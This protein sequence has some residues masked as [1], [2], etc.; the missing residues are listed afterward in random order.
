MVRDG[1]SQADR[2]LPALDP[3]YAPVDGRDT[4]AYLEYLRHY[5]RQLR[6][7]GLSNLPAGDWAPFIEG[8]I[9][10][11]AAAVAAQDA[12]RERRRLLAF[13]DDVP[14]P[15]G[16]VAFRRLL[17]DLFA[18]V[19]R[20]DGWAALGTGA[21]RF[22]DVLWQQ[23]RG[24]LRADLQLLIGI[25][26]AA[27]ELGLLAP[28][29]AGTEVTA[30]QVLALEPGLNLEWCPPGTASWV[31]CVA[32]VPAYIPAFGAGAHDASVPEAEKLARALEYLR[33]LVESFPRTL[34]RMAE[35]AADDLQR[36]L[37]DWP[38][39][40]PPMAL[41][42]TFLHLFRHALDS[43]NGLTARHLEY[44]YQEVLRLRPRGAEA[45]HLFLTFELARHLESYVVPSGTVVLGGKDAQGQPLRYALDEDLR[46][47][48]ASAEPF[49]TVHR[50][51]EGLLTASPAA[52]SADGLG[53]PLPPEQSG[54]SALGSA[55]HPA[56]AIGFALAS[57]TLLLT[58]GERTLTLELTLKA[59]PG[60]EDTLQT[61]DLARL[62]RVE[63]SIAKGWLALAVREARL[64][65]NVLRVGLRLSAADPAVASYQ[66]EIH[67]GTLDTTWPI[68]RFFLVQEVATGRTYGALA[69]LTLASVRLDVQVQGMRQ[70][71]VETDT[72]RIDPARPFA[73]FGTQPLPGS[74]FS[75]RCAE[76][77]AKA[78]TS[79][80]LGLDW[81][82]PGPELDLETVYAGY[83]LQ[84]PEPGE[85]KPLKPGVKQPLEPE[86]KQ[87]LRQ[88]SQVT[89]P[90]P[91]TRGTFR[92]E[93][94][95]GLGPVPAAGA[96]STRL[97]PLF[98]P[99]TF[100][101]PA[102]VLSTGGRARPI[103]TVRVRLTAPQHGF[104]H[105]LFP[106]LQAQVVLAFNT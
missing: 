99:A 34:A 68:C 27:A 65:G 44:Y 61:L 35:V 53:A 87:P 64:A 78:L 18:L 51:P 26:K 74:A 15:G 42:L 3:A 28:P 102:T 71:Q 14:R 45:D 97:G 59:T 41:L 106:R 13:A 31:A 95:V 24:G 12:E 94:A 38:R 93:L 7:F 57:P 9:S 103:D 69:A 67:G 8:D 89:K 50:T 83:V 5:A 46:L 16:G 40:E 37:A 104:G 98:T 58:E 70:L 79:L 32:A 101:V 6:Y 49:L 85:K 56:A 11:A 10:S 75:V 4:A 100:D 63:V 39:H 91:V 60:A 23:V 105:R 22:P 88:V 90:L 82:D 92:V 17:D 84:P 73:P 48:H 36:T 96:G 30:E 55:S 52:N 86:E 25:H 72:G 20:L 2:A 47:D 62:F 80:T 33:P 19:L 76:L 1:T 54:W 66:R 29:P 21:L 43:L 77:R 81:L